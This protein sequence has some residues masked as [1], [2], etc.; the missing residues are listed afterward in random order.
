MG[1]LTTRTSVGVVGVQLHEYEEVHTIPVRTIEGQ[2]NKD[3][4]AAPQIANERIQEELSSLKGMV[5]SVEATTTRQESKN[6]LFKSKLSDLDTL[7]YDLRQSV[8]PRLRGVAAHLAQLNERPKI[9][10][11]HAV[12]N[13]GQRCKIH[14]GINCLTRC[15]R[16]GEYDDVILNEGNGTFIKSSGTYIIPSSGMYL[17][18]PALFLE[19]DRAWTDLKTT[20]SGKSF[21]ME[22]SQDDRDPRLVTRSVLLNLKAGDGVY[23]YNSGNKNRLCDIHMSAKYPIELMGFKLN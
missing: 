16:I 8:W 5:E 13:G 9:V 2:I 17:I 20:K 14:G 10:A 1:D 18:M 15:G 12:K 22:S 7:V 3:N 4:P 19:D 6:A 21:R 23:L 11:F